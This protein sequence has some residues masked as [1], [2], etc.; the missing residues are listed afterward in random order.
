MINQLLKQH[1]LSLQQQGLY[2]KR[3]VLDTSKKDILNFS[4]NDYLSLRDNRYIKQAYKKGIN[5]YPVGSGAAMSVCGYHNIHRE[6]ENTFAHYLKADSGLLFSSGYAANL[7]IVR[8]LAQIKCQLLIDKAVHAS[9]YDGIKLTAINHKRV[10]H[11]NYDDL[12]GK[13]HNTIA[14]SVFMTEGIFSMS[15][16]QANL[17]TIA[18]ICAT[19][20]VPVIVDEAHSF[21]VIGQCGLGA[22]T[23]YQL[24]QHQVPLRLITFSKSLGGQG[25]IVV[26]QGE[27]IET[28]FQYARSNIYSTAISPALSYGVL[29]SLPILMSLDYER[30]K[31]TEL[32]AYFNQC[33]KDSPLQW[34]QSDT[35]IQQLQLGCPRR[36]LYYSLQLKKQGIICQAIRQP[37][38][39]RLTTGLRIVLNSHHEKSDIDKLFNRLYQIEHLKH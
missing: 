34:R 23:Y 12:K 20:K 6:L 14:S 38:V 16:Q 18:N 10:L 29:E 39:C 31:L 8:L 36:A 11:N 9:V 25:A 32:I 13:I 26:G 17:K 30:K 28:L 1:K 4:S 2:R 24:N 27:W 35:P 7:G 21:G 5:L 19:K 15:G 37:T 3:L 22:V 33:V